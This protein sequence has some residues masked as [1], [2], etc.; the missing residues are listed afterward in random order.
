[1]SEA[2]PKC[3]QLTL[4]DTSNA[5]FSP[6]LVAGPMPCSLPVGQQNSRSGPAVVPANR[7]RVPVNAEVRRMNGTSGQNST[8][9][10]ASADLQ[11][12]LANRLQAA[13]DLNGSMEYR[14][15]WKNSVM[16]SGRQITRLRASAHRISGNEH[17]GWRTPN[18]QDGE[19]GP[20]PNPDA[21]AGH[22]LLTTEATLAGWR[23]P[24]SNDR[25]GAIKDPAKVLSRIEAGHQVNLEDQA[26]LAGWGTPSATERSGQGEKNV[27]LMQQAR[28]VITTSSPA[29]TEKRGALNPAHS[30]W[31]QG[32]PVEWCQAAIRAFRMLKPAR[33]AA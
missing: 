18:A 19:R 13:T 5:I 3:R 30:R 9:S 6:V 14:L 2:L 24:D 17:S 12:S 27:S 11:R 8:V 23:S 25:G 7:F 15:T 22:H 21:K 1:M 20:H 26:V 33:R 29:E 10:S 4:W 32:Y 28:G 31:L 16:P